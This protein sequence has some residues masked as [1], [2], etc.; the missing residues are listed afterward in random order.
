MCWLEKP[1][2]IRRSMVRKNHFLSVGTKFLTI[3]TNF[4]ALE[5]T[6]PRFLFSYG[7]VE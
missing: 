5:P 3:G 6:F 1:N 4:W 7:P 2:K